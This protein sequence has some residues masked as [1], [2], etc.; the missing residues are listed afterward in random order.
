[1]IINVCNLF[2]YKVDEIEEL[3]QWLRD[4]CESGIVVFD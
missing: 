2:G 1:M 3:L 4:N